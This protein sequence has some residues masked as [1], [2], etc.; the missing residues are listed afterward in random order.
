MCIFKLIVINLTYM[1]NNVL[2]VILQML[3]L[4]NIIIFL[5]LI[6]ILKRPCKALKCIKFIVM[7]L[8]NE[9]I[10]CIVLFLSGV[11]RV[12]IMVENNLKIGE[13]RDC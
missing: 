3:Q 7:Q 5:L 2:P 1:I 12:W 6:Y 8:L 11:H 13:Q 9:L 4:L 10:I